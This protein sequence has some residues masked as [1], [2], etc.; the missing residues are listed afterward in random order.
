MRFIVIEIRDIWHG[1]YA[2]DINYKNIVKM[3]D[4]KVKIRIKIS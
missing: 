3:R 4:G 1:S 2:F